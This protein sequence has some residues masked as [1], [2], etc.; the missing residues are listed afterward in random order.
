MK[1]YL[2]TTDINYNRDLLY[3][4]LNILNNPSVLISKN[5]YNKYNDV[6][7]YNYKIND[8]IS[9][10]EEMLVANTLQVISYIPLNVSML[11]NTDINV[12]E[13]VITLKRFLFK[14]IDKHYNITPDDIDYVY[15]VEDNS[16]NSL[17]VEY[18]FYKNGTLICIP[19]NL[20]QYIEL[21]QYLGYSFI[22]TDHLIPYVVSQI[23]EDLDLINIDGLYGIS[24]DSFEDWEEYISLN[25][26]KL[27][28]Q[29]VI[30]L[31]SNNKEESNAW[32]EL[33]HYW[34]GVVK[35]V[36]DI[37]VIQNT[38]PLDVTASTWYLQNG[39]RLIS[40]G[41]P[42]YRF[43]VDVE[44]I[45]P[46]LKYYVIL[47]YLKLIDNYPELLNYINDIQVY[48][49]GTILA[50]FY[51]YD[52]VLELISLFETVSDI[53]KPNM[54]KIRSIDEGVAIKFDLEKGS[55]Q[56]S[57][58]IEH[59]GEYYIFSDANLDKYTDAKEI[60]NLVDNF[61][62]ISDFKSQAIP[63]VDLKS[64]LI[65]N[66]LIGKIEELRVKAANIY[67]DEV[68]SRD[69]LVVA[70]NIGINENDFLLEDYNAYYLTDREIRGYSNEIRVT[71]QKDTL[72]YNTE[73]LQCVYE[74]LVREK[75]INDENIKEMWQRGEF[76]K[77]WSKFVYRD[78]GFFSRLELLYF[79]S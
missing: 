32:V 22:G 25:V 63:V 1:E 20:Y 24:T 19:N 58:L 33:A 17:I 26:T 68:T 76:F 18:S 34:K 79:I 37:I 72:L 8:L 57:L 70:Y 60:N 36:D 29:Q 61:A 53:I 62:K 65:Q 67:K 4:L 56:D 48:D 66:N 78:S 64:Q 69:D 42:N 3:N 13:S 43:E 7:S 9:S 28:N 50:S 12:D 38:I 30:A 54:L 59:A 15:R 31:K 49:D 2:F 41:V 51:K 6:Y 16:N 71:N 55:Q 45:Q 52:Q 39:K 77:E 73:V 35:R 23:E 46:L 74:S 5:I 10:Q 44:V 75:I 14:I 21:D 11:V 47:S 27:K 40:G